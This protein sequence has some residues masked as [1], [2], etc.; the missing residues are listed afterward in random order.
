MKETKATV[1]CISAATAYY[2]S[3]ATY[4]VY[5]DEAKVKYTLASDGRYD[6]L[7]KTISKFVSKEDNTNANKDLKR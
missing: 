2:Q 5:E 3:G 7:G 1:V 6:V 4:P